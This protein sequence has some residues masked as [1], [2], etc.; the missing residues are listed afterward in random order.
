MMWKV[1][2]CVE[3]SESRSRQEEIRLL[4]R[5]CYVQNT[6]SGPICTSGL[7]THHTT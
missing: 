5:V 4:L 1:A 6:K 7:T 3:R 2:Q